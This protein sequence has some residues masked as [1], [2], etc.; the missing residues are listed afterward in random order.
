M[1]DRH[2]V[3]PTYWRCDNCKGVWSTTDRVPQFMPRQTYRVCPL[4][5][6][7]CTHFQTRKPR[8]TVK[9]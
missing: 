7:A 6:S 1:R 4:C 5:E 3:K 8:Q 2:E 9:P